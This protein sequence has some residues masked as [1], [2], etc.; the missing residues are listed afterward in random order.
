MLILVCALIGVAGIVAGGLARR[1]I[2]AV[3]RTEAGPRNLPGL[4]W[5]ALT[6]GIVVGVASWP[7]TGLMRY[8]YSTS[9]G[10]GRVVGLPFMVAYFDAAGRDYVSPLSLPAIVGNVAFFALFPQIVLSGYVVAQR[11]RKDRQPQSR[12]DV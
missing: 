7:L 9:K 6:V 2:R 4:R 3:A 11:R 5:V 1:F 10:V 12:T 8:P